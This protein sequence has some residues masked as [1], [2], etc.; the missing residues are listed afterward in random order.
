MHNYFKFL[1]EQMAINDQCCSD[2]IVPIE[3][4]LM[5]YNCSEDQDYLDSIKEHIYVTT[6]DN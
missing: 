1:E 5:S 4:L 2:T 3:E 6:N